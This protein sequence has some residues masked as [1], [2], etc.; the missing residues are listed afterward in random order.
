MKGLG[1]DH[2]ELFYR[3]ERV[4][5]HGPRGEFSLSAIN[6]IQDVMRY[7]YDSDLMQV[8]IDF[9]ARLF[10]FLRCSDNRM[11]SVTGGL[12]KFPDL[13]IDKNEVFV[14]LKS[15]LNFLV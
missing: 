2:I 12:E 6:I 3:H 10:K 1:P 9:F 4:Q 7:Q 13:L 5:K 8:K 14:Q 15:W 11:S